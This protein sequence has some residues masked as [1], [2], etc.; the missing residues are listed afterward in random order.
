M[1]PGEDLPLS[2][3]DEI[4]DRLQNRV[5]IFVDGGACGIEPT[6]VLD[7]STGDVQVVR[8]GKGPVDAF[9]G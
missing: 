1:L 5:D 3:P 4:E 6:T 8:R 9:E 2:D 7:L